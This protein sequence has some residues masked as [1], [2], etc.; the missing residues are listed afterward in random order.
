MSR[1]ITPLLIRVQ[2]LSYPKGECWVWS[3]QFKY[4][5]PVVFSFHAQAMASVRRALALEQ[6]PLPDGARH[7]PT[8]GD[9]RCVSP[10]HNKRLP[11]GKKKH[12]PSSQPA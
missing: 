10:E 8:C 2:G 6:G 12:L 4:G 7:K 5:S 3:G 1:P 9:P 11:V